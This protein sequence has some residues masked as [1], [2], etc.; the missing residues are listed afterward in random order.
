MNVSH[1]PTAG[2]RPAFAAFKRFLALAAGV[3]L[4]VVGIYFFRFPNNFTTGG[5]TG[6]SMLLAK[7]VPALS[8]SLFSLTLNMALL[9]VGFCFLGKDFGLKT[10]CCSAAFSLLLAGAERLF[11]MSAPFTDDPLMELIF[12][13]MLP[14]CGSAIL[15]NLDAS[16]GG[17]D[18]IAMLMKKYTNINISW[19]LLAVDSVV[20]AA[21]FAVFGIRAGLYSTL[22][23]VAKSLVI[24]S[25][26][27]SIN[28]CKYLHIVC[29][30]KDEICGYIS[31]VLHRG[32][33]VVDA[34]GAYT[35]VHNYVILTAMS[36]PQA[37]RLRRFIRQADPHAFMMIT[38]TSEIIGNGFR[39]G[40]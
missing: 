35:H 31:T 5:V 13:V 36:R 3:L 29:S 28:Q 40:N 10:A 23:L 14:A 25:V 9:V 27:E 38:N 26:I 6:M 20:V 2:R 1:A 30:N 18:I 39:S 4:N 11:P 7:F 17:T 37:V 24:D 19:S 12:A 8:P 34:Q 22:G 16:T 33:T 21:T 32:A 15:F